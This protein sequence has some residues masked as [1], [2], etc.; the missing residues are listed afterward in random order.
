MSGDYKTGSF[1]ADHLIWSRVAGHIPPS[2]LVYPI[3]GR[4]LLD[5][6]PPAHT[7]GR[8]DRLK[9]FHTEFDHGR[10]VWPT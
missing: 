1:R 5:S 3:I 6:A 7:I 10:L 2:G 8:A 9:S 4:V